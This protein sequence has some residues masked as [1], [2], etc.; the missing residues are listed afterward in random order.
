MRRRRL[1][2]LTAT[3]TLREQSHRRATLLGIGALILLS[4]S[5]VVGHHLLPFETDQWLAGV[6]HFGA[7]CLTALHLLFAPVHP[8]VHAAL[9][10]GLLYAG[11][12]RY[13]AWRLVRR[14]L[15]LLDIRRARR[16]DGFWEAA[17]AADV[18]PRLLRIVPGLPNPAFTAGLLQPRIYVSEALGGH[19]EEAELAAVMAHEG[20]HV[21]RRDPLRL[22]V[23]RALACT[24][25]WLPALR[26]LA[27]DVSDQAE[28]LAD[29][30]AARDQ[31]LVLASAILGVAHWSTKMAHSGAVVCFVRPDLL[32]RRVRRLAGEE[33]PVRSHV[34]RRSLLGA[35]A[36]LAVVWTSGLLLTHPLPAHAA[37]AD[38]RHCEHHDE[39][40]LS[41]LF[42][43][44]GPFA[45]SADCPHKH[46]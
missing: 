1:E 44:G 28:L 18:D 25:F 19:L 42:C 11:W 26:R 12:D 5:P 17:E 43:L 45:M 4:T 16:G 38:D 35:A 15:G 36:A 22:T 40:A 10:G 46:A 3:L 37:A 39:S 21:T 20:A 6:D 33:T 41:H 13:R 27:D 29:D 14:S 31:P 30:A 8:A 2:Y 32:E 7:L 9:A 24:L 34:T 23:L